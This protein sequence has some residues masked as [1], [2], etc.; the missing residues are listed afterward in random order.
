MVKLGFKPRPVA[1][2]I[3]SFNP[4]LVETFD[5]NPSPS[6]YKSEN[7]GSER[8]D[9]VARLSNVKSWG[10]DAALQP[11]AWCSFYAATLGL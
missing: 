4:I 9:D 1:S 5:I 2:Q 8:A 11:P 7:G 3:L 6:F 10:R